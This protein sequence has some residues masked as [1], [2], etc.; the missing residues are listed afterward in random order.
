[1]HRSHSSNTLSPVEE[2]PNARPRSLSID[3]SSLPAPPPPKSASTPNFAQDI[4]T[5]SPVIIHT[6]SPQN[7]T[8]RQ[9]PSKLD[10]DARAALLAAASQDPTDES[11]RTSVF[12]HR[13]VQIGPPARRGLDTAAKTALLDAINNDP[14]QSASQR[15]QGLA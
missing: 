6:S 9:R 11:P 8:L 1:M 10:T 3:G 13:P 2:V 15:C 7:S 12:A 14:V 5:H 4:F